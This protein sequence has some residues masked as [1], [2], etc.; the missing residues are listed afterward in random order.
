MPGYGRTALVAAGAAVALAL[1][2]SG[3]PRDPDQPSA[4]APARADAGPAA[5]DSRSGADA[6][7]PLTRAECRRL[8]DHVVD[9]AV[10]EQAQT[11]PGQPPPADEELERIRADLREALSG[12][13]VGNARAGFDC[14]M[15]AGTPEELATCEDAFSP[16]R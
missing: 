8:I 5:R 4:P 13:C 11:N 14:A 12:R 15:A 9:I 2:C 3:S 7:P 6:S 16:G 10:R 1:A